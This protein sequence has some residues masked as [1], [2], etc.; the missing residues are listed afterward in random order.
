MK[1]PLPKP[2]A[3]VLNCRLESVIAAAFSLS[4]LAFFS[5]TRVFHNFTFGM[6][7]VTFILLPVGIL[8]LKCL[9]QI[10]LAPVGDESLDTRKFLADFFRPFLKI[11]RDWFPFLVL[12]AC[13]YSLYDNLI[14]RVNPHTA[15][16]T[17]AGI[18]RHL[19]GTQPSLFLE[20]LLNP[21]LTDFLMLVYFSHVVFFPGVALY[22]YV[23]KEEAK[24]RRVMMGFLTIMIMGIASY[25][26]VP[27]AGPASFFAGQYTR[28]LTGHSLTRSV[29]Y[30]IRTGRVSFD[31]FPSLHVGIPFLLSFYVRDY[32]RKAYLP[33]L[34]YVACMAFGTIYL[35]YHYVVD[36]MASFAYAPAAYWLND[37][38]LRH[39]PGERLS[40]L[41]EEVQKRGQP[42]PGAPAQPAAVE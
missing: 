32:L 20:P 15:D 28:D 17:L 41:A 26:L 3:F 31:C 16:A 22:F 13:Y 36:V 12:C 34:L 19:F 5:V 1:K 11:L 24:F 23:K 21:Y 40:G 27:A 18:D 33:V 35:R 10:V 7:D 29:D 37:F 8:T 2:I 42:V 25:I 39:W 9:L 30:I 38:M 6:L 4:L 14:L